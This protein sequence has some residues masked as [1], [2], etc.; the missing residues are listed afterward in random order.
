MLFR[1]SLVR[2]ASK[3]VVRVRA[4]VPVPLVPT[5]ELSGSRLVQS[6]L[7]KRDYSHIETVLRVLTSCD[8]GRIT[9]QH[10]EVIEPLREI[11][12]NVF[13]DQAMMKHISLSQLG[14]LIDRSSNMNL[15]RRQDIETALMRL[16]ADWKDLDNFEKQHACLL[17]IW[18]ASLWHG[19]PTDKFHELGGTIMEKGGLFLPSLSR[20]SWCIHNDPFTKLDPSKKARADGL[21]RNLVTKF[22]LKDLARLCQHQSREF[23]VVRQ[24]ALELIASRVS[25]L[26]DSLSDNR[27]PSLLLAGWMNHRMIPSDKDF[28]DSVVTHCVDFKVNPDL[29]L[30]AIATFGL[31]ETIDVERI[32]S[33]IFKNNNWYPS[34]D[35]LASYA[36]SLATIGLV[37]IETTSFLAKHLDQAL[38]HRNP[39]Y[40]SDRLSFSN[41]WQVGAWYSTVLDTASD[42]TVAAMHDGFRDLCSK[43]ASGMWDSKGSFVRNTVKSKMSP[44]E[45]AMRRVIA[46]SL[47][48]L[49]IPTL[50][51][52]H[53][54]NTPF[55]GGLL[56]PDKQTVLWFVDDG[57]ILNNGEVVGQEHL[58]TKII[59]SKGY[60]VKLVKISE[61][62][63]RHA[64]ESEEEF[65]ANLLKFLDSEP[66]NVSA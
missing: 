23:S 3:N 53:I 48:S 38:V 1:F 50:S 40:R 7:M 19:Y 62:E 39:T 25:S 65:L 52:V 64:Q 54:V 11:C 26:K 51:Q 60:I 35:Q 18:S 59:E 10:W 29:A 15:L 56:I 57:N 21:I 12:R 20:L 34:V 58:A 24:V 4:A 31:Q 6:I 2:R 44:N 47:G 14:T 45:R 63:R 30:E 28:F 49:G 43:I 46:H 17:S 41:L 9:L 42:S 61:F 32:K 36:L 37:D 66:R 22:S 27:I 8:N 33:I 55:V 5:K 13:E 16:Q